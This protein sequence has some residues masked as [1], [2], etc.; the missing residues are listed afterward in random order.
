MTQAISHSYMGSTTTVDRDRFQCQLCADVRGVDKARRCNECGNMPY[1][2]S[3][4]LSCG[5]CESS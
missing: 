1:C 5:G 2:E 3:C 4:V